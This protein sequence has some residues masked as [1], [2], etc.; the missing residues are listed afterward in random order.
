MS[1]DSLGLRSEILNAITEAG[2]SE[3][4]PIQNTAIPY[5][6]NGI[7]LTG[8]AQTG[9]GKTAAFT[10][11]MLEKLCLGHGLKTRRTRALVLSPT[12]ELVVQIEENVSTYAKYLPLEV[13][14]VFG[15]VGEKPQKKALRDGV[16]LIIATPGRLMDLMGQGFA[17][18]SECEFFV[19]D[20]AD[21]MLDMGFLPNVRKIVSS[22]LSVGRPCCSP[23]HFPRKSK[24]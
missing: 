21:R 10:L 2:Y 8:I 9:T 13:A 1:F 19:L 7:D 24:N 16:E 12:R 6:L 3:P 4:T 5:I 23:P 11:P 15:G 14:T 18:F 22:L 17:N 20:E